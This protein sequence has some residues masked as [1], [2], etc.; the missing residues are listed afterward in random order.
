MILTQKNAL[1]SFPR[2]LASFPFMRFPS[3]PPVP[4]GNEDGF[5]FVLKTD[6]YVAER[7]NMKKK[8]L[9]PS[10]SAVLGRQGKWKDYSCLRKAFPGVGSY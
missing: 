2:A 7:Y 1:A 4:G 3:A 5:L 9:L 6:L 8:K 10:T